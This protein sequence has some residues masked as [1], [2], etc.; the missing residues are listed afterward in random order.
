MRFTFLNDPKDIDPSYK[1]DLDLWDCFGKKKLHL[2]T[3]E[4]EEG[5]FIVICVLLPLHSKSKD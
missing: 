3:E 1:M 2:I 5:I 4:T